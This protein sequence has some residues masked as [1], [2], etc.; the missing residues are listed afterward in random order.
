MLLY[1]EISAY[2]PNISS[3]LSYPIVWTKSLPIPLCFFLK[4]QLSYKFKIF[5]SLLANGP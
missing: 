3:I 5:K 4:N 1:R 2:T